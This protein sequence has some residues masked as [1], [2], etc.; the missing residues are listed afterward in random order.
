[1]SKKVKL[2]KCKKGWIPVKVKRGKNTKIVCGKLIKECGPKK[3]RLSDFC[4]Y[5]LHVADNVAQAIMRR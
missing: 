4:W 3:G 1:M 2:P 5:A